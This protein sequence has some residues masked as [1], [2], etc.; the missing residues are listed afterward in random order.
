MSTLLPINLVV[1]THR[2]VEAEV[3][4][5]VV[6]TIAVVKVK[7][8][9]A[10]VTAEVE[11]TVEVAVGEVAAATEVAVSA[12]VAAGGILEF[13]RPTTLAASKTTGTIV[14]QV[15]EVRDQDIHTIDLVAEA[16]TIGEVAASAVGEE[17]VEA[18][19]VGDVS[20]QVA[21]V[22]RVIHTQRRLDT[23]SVV[24]SDRAR[25]TATGVVTTADVDAGTTTPTVDAVTAET[26][27]PPA[28]PAAADRVVEEA[29]HP[30]VTNG[31]QGASAE[32]A[33]I[34]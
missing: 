28:V 25:A 31:I 4:R 26:V 7:G 20:V 9:K 14:S 29:V 11:V 18:A 15:P 12:E 2:A 24:D 21:T 22:A 34:W 8:G 13:T 16:G 5:V 17:E 30:R 23:F 10:V 27:D 33:A 3:A 1:T 32:R 19:A 6:D